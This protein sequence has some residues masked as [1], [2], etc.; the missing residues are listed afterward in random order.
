MCASS[1]R[2]Q[3]QQGSGW[4]ACGRACS[5]ALQCRSRTAGSSCWTTAACGRQRQVRGRSGRSCACCCWSPC[6]W[7]RQSSGTGSSSRQMRPSSSSH[8]RHRPSSSSN[9]SS[10][11]KGQLA[12][13]AVR[14]GQW[15]A[16]AWRSCSG[17]CRQSG[18]AWT[19]TCAWTRAFPCPGYAGSPPVIRD[20][21]FRRRWQG[22][23]S[24]ATQPPAIAAGVAAMPGG[25]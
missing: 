16:A 2:S 19:G 4:R 5:P 20:A 14:R 10:S 18:S 21:A 24:F 17:S 25:G 23:A 12:A 6:A 15:S 13:P 7:Q 8:R 3:Q 1:A 11:S 22:L 9:G